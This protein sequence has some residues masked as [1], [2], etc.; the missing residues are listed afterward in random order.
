M[1]E[2]W[3]L[4]IKNLKRKMGIDVDD[5]WRKCSLCF[6]T[7][8]KDGKLENEYCDYCDGVGRFYVPTHQEMG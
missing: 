5:G 4:A 1:N 6:G 2:A 8:H 7:G 3:E